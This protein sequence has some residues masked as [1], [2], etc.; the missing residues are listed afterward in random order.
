[1]S[2]VFLCSS[3]WQSGNL[4][5]DSRLPFARIA[6]KPHLFPRATAKAAEGVT[7]A[8]LPSSPNNVPREQAASCGIETGSEAMR[9]AFAIHAPVRRG[10]TSKS[11]EQA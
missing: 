4:G 2:L 11:D 7:A 9:F 8:A 5:S 6:G 1:V 10:R 3:R